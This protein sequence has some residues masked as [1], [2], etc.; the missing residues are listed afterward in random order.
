MLAIRN[1]RSAHCSSD[2]NDLR[3]WSSE[4]LSP[5]S[6]FC[7]I[8]ELACDA[9]DGFLAGVDG[10]A[11]GFEALRGAVEGLRAWAAGDS[12]LLPCCEG[13]FGGSFGGFLTEGGAAEDSLE[14][15]C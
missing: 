6:C 10:L 12:L 1:V 14:F 13:C 4:T 8:A 2:K 3:S 15:A 7:E 5:F 9:V 11:A